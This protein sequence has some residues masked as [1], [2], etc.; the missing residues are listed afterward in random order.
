M[1]EF[2]LATVAGRATP[3]KDWPG[4]SRGWPAYRSGANRRNAEM[5][6]EIEQFMCRTDN[7]GVLIN[8]LESGETVIID[9]PE[10]T[11]I[12][13]A[14]ERTEWRPTALWITHHHG[15]HVAA[16]LAL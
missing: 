9:A 5:A 10:E 15:D 12:L 14:V 6:V 7:F 4:D 1:S 3:F 11:P 16:N 13:A 8:D 2:M